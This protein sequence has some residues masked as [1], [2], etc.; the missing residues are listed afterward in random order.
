M[1]ENNPVKTIQTAS[2][3]TPHNSSPSPNPYTL[4]LNDLATVGNTLV[5][6]VSYG[7]F[8]NSTLTTPPDNTWTALTTYAPTSGHSEGLVVYTKPV[9]SVYQNSVTLGHDGSGMQILLMEL[10][11]VAEFTQ[12]HVSDF[13]SGPPF[14][15][16]TVPAINGDMVFAVF[17]QDSGVGVDGTPGEGWVEYPLVSNGYNNLEVQTLSATWCLN[18][19]WNLEWIVFTFL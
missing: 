9:T 14:V 5:V 10:A 8:Y 18:R 6:I 2:Y 16:T 15:T 19:K 3:Q 17:T 1:V 7:A 13:Q 11:N 4:T 12:V